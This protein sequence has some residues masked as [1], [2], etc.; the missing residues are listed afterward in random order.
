MHQ[1]WPNEPI[2][3]IFILNTVQAN[4]SHNPYYSKKCFDFMMQGL[5]SLDTD[6]GH[7]LAVLNSSKLGDLDVLEKLR[8]T[9]DIKSIGFN[10]DLTPFARKRDQLIKDWCKT[11]GIECITST[12]EYSLVP[13]MTMAKPALKYTP[14]FERYKNI[15]I[16][17]LPQTRFK[18]AK[19]KSSLTKPLPRLV[20]GKT[21]RDIA[22]NILKDIK[23]G[24]FKAYGKTRDEPSQPTTRLS[25]YL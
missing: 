7:N 25:R 3:P 6:T 5:A 18:F 15:K 14:F 12:E 9:H 23:S 10:E 1:R 16:N 8:K 11:N 4:P 21:E 13:P 22:L 2:T 17:I 20:G 24:A 19:I